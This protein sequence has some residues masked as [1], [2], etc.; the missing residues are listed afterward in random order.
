MER[1]KK[2]TKVNI[3]SFE[4]SVMNAIYD[5]ETNEIVGYRVTDRKRPAFAAIVPLYAVE[6]IPEKEND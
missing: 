3:K 6:I 5:V 2:G 4:A 1:L